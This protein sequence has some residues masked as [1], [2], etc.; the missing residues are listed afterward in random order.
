[1]PRQTSWRSQLSSVSPSGQVEHGI[2]FFG[3]NA[4]SARSAMSSVESQPDC[5]SSS[6]NAA[7]I[8]CGLLR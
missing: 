8:S 1:M 5:H 2:R 6:L 3:W 4:T 7:R